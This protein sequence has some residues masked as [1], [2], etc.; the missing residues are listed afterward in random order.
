MGTQS[1]F[2]PCKGGPRL[3]L[4]PKIG[5]RLLMGFQLPLLCLFPHFTF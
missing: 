4:P 3:P 1:D 2:P 5:L